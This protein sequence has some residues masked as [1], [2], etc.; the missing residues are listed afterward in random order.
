MKHQFQPEGRRACF[1]R[2]YRCPQDCGMLGTLERSG[3]FF[4]CPAARGPR[5]SLL[6][7]DRQKG[8]TAGTII[9]V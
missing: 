2:F 7:R 5:E 1:S 8:L 4:D 3:I 6:F 9:R